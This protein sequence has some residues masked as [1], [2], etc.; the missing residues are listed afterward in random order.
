M[1]RHP[2]DAAAHAWDGLTFKALA[3]IA[4]VIISISGALL[5]AGVGPVAAPSQYAAS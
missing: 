3:G 2:L 4:A 5:L 1:L